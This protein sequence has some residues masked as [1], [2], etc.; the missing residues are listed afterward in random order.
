MGSGNYK[1]FIFD[2]DGTI[3]DTSQ[4][5]LQAARYTIELFHKSMPEDDALKNF[6][7]PPLRCSF[8]TL[9]DVLEEDVDSMVKTFRKQYSEKELFHA[10]VYDG[11][12]P[13][14]QKLKLNDVKMAVATNKP[15]RFAKQ[16]VQHFDLEQYIPIVCGA[17]EQGILTKADLIFRVID[18]V[19]IED[20]SQVVMV[21]DTLGDADAAGK[22][23]IDFIGVTYGFGFTGDKDEYV[24]TNAIR[25]VSSPIEIYEGVNA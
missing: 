9:A 25:M 12:I 16:L 20:K 15:E 11:F 3:L 7:G 14:C 19:G 1:L 22:C 17:D 2:M 24:R 10:V 6:I 8:A 18:L 21:G 5:I 4:G 13:L 23:G